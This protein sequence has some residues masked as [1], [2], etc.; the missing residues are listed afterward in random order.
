MA[1][2]TRFTGRR[3]V[4]SMNHFFFI[5]IIVRCFDVHAAAAAIYSGL[6]LVGGPRVYSVL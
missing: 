1:T 4:S 3:S 5:I 6:Q 2:R